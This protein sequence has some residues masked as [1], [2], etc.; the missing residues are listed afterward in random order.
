MKLFSVSL[1]QEN[2]LPVYLC[3]CVCVCVH[4]FWLHVWLKATKLSFLWTFFLPA[5]LL[6]S[7]YQGP[8][9]IDIALGIMVQ[10]T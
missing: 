7:L 5:F 8:V 2:L 9:D 10:L 6:V 4:I 3:V 1:F